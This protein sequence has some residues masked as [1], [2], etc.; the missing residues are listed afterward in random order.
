MDDSKLKTLSKLMVERNLIFNLL[1]TLI[2]DQELKEINADLFKV[3]QA[4]YLAKIESNDINLTKEGLNLSCSMCDGS[5]DREELILSC[6]NCGNPFHEY[7]LK[8]VPEDLENICPKCGSIFH[9]QE[10]DE[11]LTIEPKKIENIYERF[12]NTIPEIAVTVEGKSLALPHK[13]SDLKQE[14][15]ISGEQKSIGCPN[16]GQDIKLNWRFCKKCGYELKEELSG[17]K[18]RCRNC[19]TSIE[20]SWRFCKWCGAPTRS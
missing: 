4:K 16:C 12:K 13:I 14:K 3:I 5:I 7:H 11:F 17:E 6:I 18:D 2:R 1:K 10:I 15:E 19:G 20:P 9:V 8:D